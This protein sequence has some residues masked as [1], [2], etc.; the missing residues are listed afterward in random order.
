MF[1]RSKY[2]LII[3]VY[4]LSYNL[5]VAHCTRVGER[6]QDLFV[7]RLFSLTF[8]P[9][10]SDS[11]IPLDTSYASNQ[12]LF[13]ISRGS[14]IHE[15]ALIL[16]FSKSTS[17]RKHQMYRGERVNLND[18]TVLKSGGLLIFPLAATKVDS[19]VIT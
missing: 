5:P 3:D 2:I 15:T 19:F 7:F 14:F 18:R 17:L 16:D 13:C 9:S 11:Q 8:P 1:H 6:T 10:H 12:L 4:S